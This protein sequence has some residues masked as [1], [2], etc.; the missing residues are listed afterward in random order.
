MQSRGKKISPLSKRIGTGVILLVIF[1]GCAY[2]NTMFNALQTYDSA[3][4]QL[5][6]NTSQEIPPEIRKDFETT[7]DKCWKLINIYGEDSNYADDALLLI[8][9][10]NFYLQE[11]S[12]SERFAR[13]MIGKYPESDLIPE[14]NLWLARSLIKLNRGDEATGF[15]N[16][17]IQSDADD[18]LKSKAWF[19]LGELSEA[20][21][22]KEQAVKELETSIEYASDDK[23]ISEAR[24]EIGQ[25]YYNDK[26]YKQAAEQ[27]EILFDYDE[28]IAV[29]FQSQMLRV[30]AL[31]KLKDP[32]EAQYVLNLMGR[33]TRFFQFQDLIQAK[34]GE[35]MVQ[36]GTIPEAIDQFQYTL[37]NYPHT[38]GSARAAFGLADVLEHTYAEYDS[39]RKLYLRVKQEDR[40][41]DLNIV[42]GPRA[43]TLDQ[44]LKLKD[45]IRFDIKSLN[46][47]STAEETDTLSQPEAG[48]YTAVPVIENPSD[49]LTHQPAVAAQKTARPLKKRDP[50]EIHESLVKN[51]FALAEFFLLT[52]QNYDSAEVAYRR[53]I[54]T[55]QDSVLIPK[56][57]YAL[58]YIYDFEKHERSKAD[59]VKRIIL[60]DYPESVY[61]LHIQKHDQAEYDTTVADT[62]KL[63]YRKAE[64]LMFDEDYSEALPIFEKIAE[65]DSGSIWAEKSRY[66]I[67]WIYEKKLNEIPNA[68][69]A[70][71]II[72]REYPDTPF[73]KI[74]KLKIQPPPPEAAPDT[75]ADSSRVITGDTTITAPPDTSLMNQ[76]SPQDRQDK[77]A[78]P[79]RLEKEK[80]R[81]EPSTITQDSSK[82]LE[83]E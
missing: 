83:K 18:D 60:N 21:D 80:E 7:I 50:E 16:E 77:Q 72:A 15:L 24:Y 53:F 40:N 4:T 19:S 11:Y 27:L 20:R 46:P 65:I 14:A 42:A 81:L 69:S 43:Y 49:S 47:D 10:S 70:Y 35:C 75:L 62:V 30:D 13:Q 55:Y 48:G 33:E 79:D 58:Y 2:Y 32:D 44:Y 45:N 9:K 5:N 56:A 1:G 52:M 36:N 17:I 3:T 67:A 28:P 26:D 31:M 78:G 71:E 29:I 64:N 61:A 23:M 74:A 25:I 82:T 73:G 12:K 34:K 8:A 76:I 59:S 39:A 41:S 63:T 51:N 6:E 57:Y 38:A 37:D 22:Q 66:A 68:V 54:R